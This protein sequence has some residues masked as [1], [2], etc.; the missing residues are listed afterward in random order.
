MPPAPAK[1][2]TVGSRSSFD[3]EEFLSSWNPELLPQDDD[4]RGSLTKA[5][6]LPPKDSYVYRAI[7]E[8]T[9]DQVQHAIGFGGQH[10]LHGW[11][12]DDEDKPVSQPHQGLCE[13]DQDLL[14]ETSA[15]ILSHLSV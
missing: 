10:G 6:N 1:P 13:Q 15:L 9:L 12:V 14:L 8:V 11:Y 2:Q 3:P 5:F 4:L 7:A